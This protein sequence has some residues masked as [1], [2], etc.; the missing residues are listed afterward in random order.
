MPFSMFN[1][2]VVK[3]FINDIFFIPYVYVIGCSS[4]WKVLLARIP[5]LPFL[6]R[7]ISNFKYE[8]ENITHLPRLLMAFYISNNLR[9]YHTTPKFICFEQWKRLNSSF[10]LSNTK[11]D[12]T[13]LS[14][15]C[16]RIEVLEQ[17]DILWLRNFTAEHCTK[18][19]FTL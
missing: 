16:Q 7:L 18:Q 4:F 6:A 11:F 8:I 19:N 13:C 15:S 5:S 1:N 17:R 12:C 14:L 2:K 10:E 9:P 3:S